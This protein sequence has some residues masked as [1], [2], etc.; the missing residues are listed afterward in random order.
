MDVLLIGYGAIAS[1]VARSL[2]NDPDVRIAYVLAHK[3]RE[4]A[5]REAVGEGPVILSDVADLTELPDVAL[6]AAGHAGLAEHGTAL[7]RKGIDLGIASIGAMADDTL[8][9]ALAAAARESGAQAILLPGAIGAVDAL[10]AAKIAGLDR[11][12]YMGRKP[13]LGWI[14]SPAEEKTDLKALTEPFL[15]FEGSARDAAL[16]YPKNANV[17]ATVA[18][19]ALGLDDTKVELWA[20]PAAK[21]NTHVIEAE[22]AFGQFRFEITGK[23]LPENPKTSALTALSAL[24]F[25]RNRA[26]AIAV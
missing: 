21:G 8:S 24:R 25:L 20:D 2:K 12:T 4:G 17:A 9:A 5:A 6:E 1:Y 26:A 16:A 7:L 22:G 3:G 18:L 10:A 14:G 15:H 13:P 23:P 11:V 19:A